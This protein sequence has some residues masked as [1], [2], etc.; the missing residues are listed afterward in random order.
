M[1]KKEKI[2]PI[3]DKGHAFLIG[4]SLFKNE[5]IIGVISIHIMKLQIIHNGITKLCVSHVGIM[6][7]MNLW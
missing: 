6:I 5:N 2:K 4:V 3:T 1:Q 7:V